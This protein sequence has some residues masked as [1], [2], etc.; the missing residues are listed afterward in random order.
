MTGTAMLTALSVVLGRFLV[1]INT[2]VLRFSLGN[3]PIILAGIIFGGLPGAVCGLAA[4]IIGC[5]ISGYAPYP[6]LMLSPAAV[7]FLP[8]FFAR[9]FGKTQGGIWSVFAVSVTVTATNL[10]SALIISTFALSKLYGTEFLLLFWE[11]VPVTA[12]RTAAE[13]A[14]L[15]LL[16]KNGAVMRIFAKK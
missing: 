15:Y 3:V 8:S 11:R 1:P 7:G 4:D 2:D 10:I 14:V 13:T 12:V 16:L 5:F 9:I 6:L